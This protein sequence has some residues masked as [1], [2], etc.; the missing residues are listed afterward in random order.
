MTKTNDAR[1]GARRSESYRS[2]ATIPPPRDLRLELN[3]SQRAAVQAL[4]GPVLVLAGA[5]TGKT[6]VITCRIV[7]LI[8]SG[9]A[10]QR[11]LSVTFTN[12]AARE[13]QQR[14]A[15]LLGRPHR[16]GP[17]V[18]TFHALCVR[19]L[20]EEITHLGYPSRFQILD[21]ADQESIARSVLRAIRVSDKTLR[22]GDLLGL[23]GRMKSA[24]D[25]PDAAAAEAQS[26]RD[27]LAAMGY[28]RYQQQL[29]ATGAVDFDDLL[30][31]TDRLFAEYPEVLA[32][33]Q[34]RFD[35]VQIDEYQDTNGIQF[36]VVEAL[37]R[38]H[39]NLCV[40]GDDD[41]AIY[42]FRGADVQHILG[43]QSCFPDARVFRLEDNYRC[44]DAIL[45][46][47]NRLIRQNRSRHEKMLRG[48]KPAT[49]CVRVLEL[50]DEQAEA[51]HVVQ[52]IRVLIRSRGVPPG[53]IAI[54]FRTNEQ[55]R[56]FETELRRCSVPYVIVGTQSLYDRKEI[57]DIL[58][59]LKV[60]CHPQDEPSLLRIVNVPPRGI[61]MKTVERIHETAVR[62]GRSFWQ[63]VNE[64]A[65]TGELPSKAEAGLRA[66]ERLLHEF[67]RRCDEAP[68]QLPT[69]LQELIARIDYD[70]EI[71]R[72]YK[73]PDQQLARR[74]I[75][76]EFVE[77][78]SEYVRRS[79]APK[80]SDFLSSI[81]LDGPE[82]DFET[83]EPP[84]EDAV[85][86]MT[87]HSAKGLEFPRVYLVGLEE[88]LLPHHRSLE[89]PER[90]IE[91]ERRLAYVGITRARDVLTLTR[92]VTRRK[93][94]KSR[95][96]VP[97]R[98]LFEMAADP[99]TPS[100]T[101]NAPLR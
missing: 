15:E 33:Q 84:S 16:P 45:A 82:Q 85:R 73:E 26:D 1:S 42:G 22:P 60:L 12:K 4:S 49:E 23:I 86:L 58:A 70:A 98:F 30:L 24:G 91:E 34:A 53:E 37:V 92:A 19:I 52:E 69:L 97:S 94:G 21:R 56:P 29:R 99:T 76:D 44:T 62:T 100:D 68:A 61:G 6:R 101:A 83:D 17:V 78:L 87:L 95:E 89:G 96:T 27:F 20:R 90:N 11:V 36:R 7:Q 59:Y 67:R 32:R 93:W 48:H 80:L 28:R 41:Q 54:L 71:Q 64:L 51:A 46:V 38:A 8:R 5:G 35:H 65:Q 14:T 25:S 57:R 18:S 74:A 79:D 88:G 3:A 47:A 50:P 43:F 72:Q 55:P 77:S 40:V 75:L 2:A 10:P 9:F 66:L 81:A 39:R 13:M 31:L 63:V